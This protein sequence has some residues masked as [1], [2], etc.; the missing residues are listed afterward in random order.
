MTEAA[1]ETAGTGRNGSGDVEAA[2]LEAARD[3]LA[4]G[5]E[6][7]LSMRHVAEEV[8]ISATAIYHYFDGKQDLV[9]RVVHMGFQR[10]GAYLEEAMAAH[11]EG[12]LERMHALGKAYLRFALENKAYFRVIFSL[13]SKTPSERPELPEGGGYHLMRK[14][15]N[16]AIAAGTIRKVDPDLLSMYLWCSVHGLVTL[17]LCGATERSPLNCPPS[18]YDLYDAFRPL[19]VDGLRP[20]NSESEGKENQE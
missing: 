10:F 5:G 9:N 15:I 3:L 8:G 11:P 6:Q 7:E 2:I 17:A 14:E 13:R 20:R 1:I 4:H 16:A 19:K 18:P 12:S